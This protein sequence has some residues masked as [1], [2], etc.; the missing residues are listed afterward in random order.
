MKIVNQLIITK[1][2]S[3]SSGPETKNI[4]P[5]INHF[6]D[7]PISELLAETQVSLNHIIGE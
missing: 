4:I 2:E 5:L 7:Y 6:V 3:L 1:F